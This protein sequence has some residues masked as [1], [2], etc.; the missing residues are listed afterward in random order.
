[1]EKHLTISSRIYQNSLGQ[2]LETILSSMKVWDSDTMGI[3]NK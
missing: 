3:K 1:M 2:N